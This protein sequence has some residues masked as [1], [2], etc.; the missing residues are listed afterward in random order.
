MSLTPKSQTLKSHDIDSPVAL[1]ELP[2]DRGEFSIN[3]TSEIGETAFV[4]RAIILD[5]SGRELET[6][7]G[8]EAFEY[9]PP[10][11]VQEIV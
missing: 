4:P 8:E 6:L 2:A 9:Q 5:K 1:F 3:I 10:R 7:G 11:L